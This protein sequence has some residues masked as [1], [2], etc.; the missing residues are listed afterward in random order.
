M[1]YLGIGYLGSRQGFLA[2]IVEENQ[3]W[4]KGDRYPRFFGD[5]FIVMYDSNT[6]REFAR[7]CQVADDEDRVVV[8][9]MD[10]PLRRRPGG[11]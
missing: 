1:A 7:K 11:G 3:E 10:R 5:S 9:T 6:A 2:D 8:Y 4:L